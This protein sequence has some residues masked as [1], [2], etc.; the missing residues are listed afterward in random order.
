MYDNAIFRQGLSGILHARWT[1]EC[2][3]PLTVRNGLSVSYADRG[4][5]K[6]RG[7]NVKFKWQPKVDPD[8]ELAALAYGYEVEGSKVL[9]YHAIPASSLR[10][11]LRSW[12]INYLVRSEFRGRLN[13]PRKRKATT[14]RTMRTSLMSAQHRKIP[15]VA[16]LCSPRCLGLRWKLARRTR[17]WR[18]RDGSKWKQRS[19]ARRRP[20]PF[21]PTASSNRHG[22]T[23]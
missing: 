5:A 16:M 4:P 2:K 19:S 10:G 12:T 23:G 20:S 7:L 18:T 6:S 21:P 15:R 14:P 9:S 8:Y 17:T 3:T 1:L 13:R 22:G 11:A